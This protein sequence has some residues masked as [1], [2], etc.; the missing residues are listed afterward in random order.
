AN[1]R[2]IA[3]K[4]TTEGYISGKFDTRS[5]FPDDTHEQYLARITGWIVPTETD[6]YY[7]FL[8]SDDAG[9]LYLSQ[10][11]SIPD[12]LTTEPI[13]IESDCCGAFMDPGTDPATTANPIHLTANQRYGV[14][15]L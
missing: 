7:F 14:L 15:A 8:R 9:R 2:V 13:A 1:A 3:D 12:P 4:P 6:D 5:I 10:D 11:Q